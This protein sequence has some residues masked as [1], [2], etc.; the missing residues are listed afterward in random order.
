MGS[1]F[2]ALMPNDSIRRVHLVELFQGGE[3]GVE[4]VEVKTRRD[5]DVGDHPFGHPAVDGAG[6]DRQALGEILLLDQGG[7]DET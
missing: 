1:M 6:A 2:A 5:L 7:L 4:L 3:D